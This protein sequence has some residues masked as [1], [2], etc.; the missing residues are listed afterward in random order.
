MGLICLLGGL[1]PILLI[2]AALWII[3]WV[4]KKNTRIK[5]LDNQDDGKIVIDH[6]VMR[7]RIA[8]MV[9]VL[10]QSCYYCMAGPAT[11]IRCGF[12]RPV[13]PRMF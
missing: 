3:D 1:F 9:Q 7:F 8:Q 12:L 5:N 2:L 4:A 13:Y 10:S 6:W 11:K